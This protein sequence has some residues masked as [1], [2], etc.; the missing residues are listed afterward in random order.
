MPTI[1]QLPG[2]ASVSDA[3]EL[4]V[5]QNG[6]TVAATRAQILAGTQQALALPQGTMLGGVG[7]GVASPVPISIGAN[8]ALNGTTLSATAAP[9]E[10][11]QLASGVSPG[12]TDLV[13]LAQSGANVALPYAAFM[14]GISGVSGIGA[15]GFRAMAAGA[16]TVRS[17]AA[18]GANAVAI[19]DFGAAGDGVTDDAGALLAALASGNPV[20]FGPRTYRIDGECDIGGASATLL[21]VVGSTVLTRGAQSAAGTSGTPAWISVSATQFFADG[22]VF[23]ANRAVTAD[24]WG[25][26]VQASCT[27][28]NITRSLFRNAMGSIF[29]WGLAFAPSDPTLTRHHV[30]DCEFTANAVDGMWVAACDS[31]AVTCCRAHDNTRNGIYVDSQDP[32]FVLKIRDVQIVGNTCWNNQTGISVGNFNATNTEPG[33]YGNGNPDVLG[34]LVANNCT[35]NNT[36]YGISVSGRNILVSGNLIVDNG[37]SG[38]GMLA[39]TGY[40]RISDNMITGSGG[41]GIDAGGSIFVDITGNYIDGPTIGIGIGGSQNC[42]VRGN[43]VQDCPIGLIALNVESDGRGDSFGI[44]CNNLSIVGNFIGYDAGGSGIIL[45]DAPQ[46]VLIADNVVSSGV[47][48][49]PLNA[50]VPGTDSLVLRNNTINY[51]DSFA[52]NPLIS[53]GLNTLVYPDLVDRVEVSQSS[54]LIAS[55]ISA[56]AQS[57]AGQIGFIKVIDG[58]SNYTTASV[59]ISGS[60]T[61]ASA[62]VWIA[63]GVVIGVAITDPGS[64]YGAGTQVLI[65]GDGS[66]A[67]ASVQVG[68]PV[69][70]GRLLTVHCLA[71]AGFAAAGS[72]P[73][74][75]NWTGAPVTVPAGASI[76]WQGVAGAW[77]AVR[78]MQSDYVSPDGDGSVTVQSQ[79]GD[80]KLSPAAGGGVRLCSRFEPTGCVSLIGRGSPAGVVP[81]TPGSSYRNLNGGVGATYWV[82]QSASDASGWAAIA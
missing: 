48:G 18:I 49:N 55:M 24:T 82:K 23:D 59:S 45:R 26:V 6:V 65:D 72:E 75:E 34:G 9:F 20:R 42:T 25:V 53:G 54:G 17:F 27:Y 29:G 66:G 8:L 19:E 61:G 33:V 21:G 80:V 56:A 71:P 70:Q 77:Q 57:M 79:A 40:C 22:I 32:T 44:S 10:I 46:R 50:L 67:T 36:G 60:G 51:S 28:A 68:L 62:Q 2:A 16:T 1:G 58:G 7:P 31:V 43:Y 69:V 73:A 81:A 41:F 74:Q 15:S 39:N 4:P 35:F 64:G 78:F 12:A 76:E 13:P 52:V 47:A 11:A 14:Q 30:H 37:P 3:D 5:F 38:G 63:G